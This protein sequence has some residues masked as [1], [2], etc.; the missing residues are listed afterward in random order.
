[1]G[2]INNVKFTK[3]HII[4][5]VFSLVFFLS[6]CQSSQ[7][8]AI[9]SHEYVKVTHNEEKN[10]IIDDNTF[11][12]I[13]LYNPQY[14]KRLSIEGFFQN[15][16]Q[17][18]EVNENDASHSALGFSLED[19]FWGVTT[20]KGDNINNLM[21]EHC[22]DLS[23]NIYMNKCNPEDSFQ[24]TYAL[25]VTTQ[26]FHEAKKLVEKYANDPEVNY[27]ISTN[28]QIAGYH[29]KRRFFTPKEKRNI[30]TID[31]S[32]PKFINDPYEKDFQCASFIAF[33]L[34][35]TVDK[36]RDFFTKQALDYN[37]ITPSDLAEIPGVQE[38]FTSTWNDYDKVAEQFIY[39]YLQGLHPY[40]AGKNQHNK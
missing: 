16:I 12:F 28:I 2:R 18:V 30:K 3:L 21:L 26:E 31:V 39:E 4:V 25:L 40:T 22:T 20:P 34:I 6:S 24:T 15:L 37:K 27:S 29:L 19:D 13:R 10:I 38:L 35:N 8:I 23:N 33:I 7:D 36:V 17:F 11:I 14:I 5:L 1:M 9:P 32:E